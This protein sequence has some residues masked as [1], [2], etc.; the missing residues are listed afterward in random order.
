MTDLL[1]TLSERLAT[2]LRWVRERRGLTQAQ[3]ATLSGVP[4][5]TLANVET[6]SG[7]PT[8]SVLA[9][10]ASSLRLTVDELLS[11]PTGLGRVYR[12]GELPTERRGSRV[13]AT[14]A[15]LLPDPIAGMEIDRLGLP[16]GSRIRGVPHRPVTREYL[17]CE[18]GALVLY[19]A[20]ERHELAQGDVCA[21]QGDQPH[22]YLN[23]G[24]R[25]ATA[26]SVVTLAP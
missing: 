16:P 1:D 23:E 20:G 19:C 18:S 10:L 3:L 11:A 4:R 21:F 6:G 24:D 17:Y 2:N 13:K 9:R 7:N 14:I 8:L 15:K 5:S 12:K 26:F 25:P 22:S